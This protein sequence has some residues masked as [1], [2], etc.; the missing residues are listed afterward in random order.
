MS[1]VLDAVRV[2][3]VGRPTQVRLALREVISGVLSVH[4]RPAWWAARR[5]WGPSTPRARRALRRPAR[6]RSAASPRRWRLRRSRRGT[7]I[8]WFGVVYGGLA[9]HGVALLCVGGAKGAVT[10][11]LV[12]EDL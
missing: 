6:R 4:S 3:C 11:P 12:G 10:R 5:A 8:T 2:I 1:E 7:A 9:R